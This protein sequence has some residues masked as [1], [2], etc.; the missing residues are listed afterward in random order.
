[1]IGVAYD[2]TAQ[3]SLLRQK[4]LMLR[5]VNHRV[6]NSLQLVSSLLSL[7]H[8]SVADETLRA[9]L[10]EADRRILTIAKIHEHL[11]R[12]AEAINTIEFSGYLRD[13]CR[14]LQD[15]LAGRSGIAVV[16]DADPADLPTDRVISLALIVNE[17]VTNATKYAFP[18]AADDDVRD[19]EGEG[20]RERDGGG[21]RIDVGFCMTAEGG[22]R[23]SV[24]DN[25]RGLPADYRPENSPGLG[26]KV[27]SGLARGM[28]A[29]LAFDSS[30]NGARFS[31]SFPPSACV[32]T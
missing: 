17:L 32:S 15:T 4:E 22:C 11:Y 30:S 20:G 24:A 9:Q 27:V 26:M 3:R 19:R 7:Q 13:L 18:E 1:M 12:D 2:V 5:E 8:S 23:L 28:H 25:G 10:A 29:E 31:V 6:K 21:K 16:V 14:E